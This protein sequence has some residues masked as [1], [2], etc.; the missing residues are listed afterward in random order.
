MWYLISKND[1][2]VIYVLPGKDIVIGRSAD[3]QNCNFAFPED[4]SLSRKHATLSIVNNILNLEDVGSKYGTFINNSV[5]K[6][7][8]NKKLILNVNDT[9][10]FGKLN[11]E[12]TVQKA[13]FV[14]CASTLKGENIQN[15]KYILNKVGGEFKNEWDNTC[16]YLTMPA[17]TL[18][19]KVVLALV[20]GSYIVTTDYWT[21]CLDAISQYTKLP[22]PAQYT[23]QIVE[24][25]LNKDTVSFLPDNVRKTL[26]AGKNMVFFS[27]RQLE[28]YRMVLER[29]SGTALLLSEVN[30]SKQMLCEDNVIVIQ[31]N[32]TQPSQEISQESQKEQIK[33]IVNYLKS[34][35][36]RLVADAE[37]GLAILY[38]SLEKYC[39]PDFNFTMELMKQPSS[40]A[41]KVNNIL[42]QESQN[43][44]QGIL[45]QK[46]IKI[47]ESLTG[48][49]NSLVASGNDELVTGKRKHSEDEI[50]TN[51]K[52][53][54]ETANNCGAKRTADHLEDPQS[55]PSK[56]IATDNDSFNFIQSSNKTT[57]N[58]DKQLNFLKPIK[59]KIAQNDD[60]D[61]LFNFVNKK[62]ATEKN[63]DY[64]SNIDNSE[65][66]DSDLKIVSNNNSQ[67]INEKVDLTALRGSKLSELLEQNSNMDFSKAM[68][69]IKT[70]TDEDFGSTV[71]EVRKD[72][73]VKREP[74][75]PIKEETDR[76][77]LKNFK[78][79]KKVWPVKLQ[80]SMSKLSLSV[81]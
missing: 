29:S 50:T 26:F 45:Y 17:I 41:V 80:A 52:I 65:D 25:T 76:S 68:K 48:K 69:V 12:W 7:E 34:K 46:N 44:S 37:I 67:S 81:V 59:R 62:A 73:I 2:R 5:D 4:P 75:T 27:K 70:E 64:R 21:K 3:G 30:M 33:D 24:S 23:P 43:V 15:L 20:Q 11:C 28:M 39:N 19:I 13:D 38:C 32:A 71:I 66:V 79:F 61:G 60:E 22:D 1:P 18:T 78:K 56:K 57:E 47:D 36:K 51:K 14:T 42:A 49:E 10:K 9:I 53:A 31:Y 8:C 6:L 35:G 58:N 74:M 54:I 77:T 40:Q 55:N 16:A 72:L 63:T